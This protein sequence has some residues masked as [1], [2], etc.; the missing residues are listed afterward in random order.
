M[1]IPV[2]LCGLICGW[3]YGL[4]VGL[5]L[6]LLRSFLFSMPVLYPMAIAMAFELAAYGMLAG[7]LFGHAK[8]QCTRSLYRCLILAMI[9]G[10]IVWGCAEVLL[11][12]LGENGFTW[13]A[14]I[15]G[16]FLNAL[17]G[18]I[19]QLVLIPTIMLALD[20]THLVPFHRQRSE[21]SYAV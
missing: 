19:L 12:G 16:A 14:F 2:L 6:P 18:I 15:A 9:G 7:W 11:L 1:H 5:I 8:W 10:R 3:Q 4:A 13:S 21:D 20:K 17:P